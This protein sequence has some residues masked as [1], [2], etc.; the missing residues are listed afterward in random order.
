MEDLKEMFAQMMKFQMESQQKNEEKLLQLQKVNE[1]KILKNKEKQQRF[2]LELQKQ[3]ETLFKSLS[4]NQPTDG[5]SI[6]TQN[7]VW[8]ALE[9]FS[10]APDEDKTFEAYYRR[11]EDIFITDCAD[12]TD[13]K[14]VRL[15]L[16]KLGTVEHHKFVDYI[17]LKKNVNLAV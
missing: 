9:T 2:F 10:Y 5:T 8:N 4:N 12:W 17:F 7:A 1:E 3:Q 6:F 11:Y 14:K 15:L 16:R 13:A